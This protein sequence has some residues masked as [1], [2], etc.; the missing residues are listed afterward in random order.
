MHT[1]HLAQQGYV[2][3]VRA[4]KKVDNHTADDP[5]TQKQPSGVIAPMRAVDIDCE[6]KTLIGVILGDGR[7]VPIIGR[8]VLKVRPKITEAPVAKPAVVARSF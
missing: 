4:Q 6:R 3:I 5:C 1:S 2:E 7:N 8:D